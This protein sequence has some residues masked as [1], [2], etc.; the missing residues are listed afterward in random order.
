MVFAVQ[1]CTKRGFNRSVEMRGRPR[2]SGRL[3]IGS[4]QTLSRRS[5]KM[6]PDQ[7]STDVSA[8]QQAYAGRS[9]RDE[10]DGKR[11]PARC[12]CRRHKTNCGGYHRHARTWGYPITMVNGSL[13]A[14]FIDAVLGRIG[15]HGYWPAALPP[16]PMAHSDS[17]R[18][19]DLGYV[20]HQERFN[21]TKPLV[22]HYVS[23]FVSDQMAIV[24]ARLENN[25]MAERNSS[26]AEAAL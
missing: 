19:N 15:A 10:S 7:H 16:A 26:A 5:R 11:L 4:Y 1:G 21:S 12:N 18:E 23:E 8:A 6:H 20:S 17:K 24:S 14:P 22:L 3:I 25:A 9:A 2:I 13:A